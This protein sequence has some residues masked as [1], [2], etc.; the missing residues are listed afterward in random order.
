[1]NRAS[2]AIFAI[3]LLASSICAAA[4]VSY[5]FLRLSYVD[6]ELD[7]GP[8]DVDGDG[9][10]L[11]G[12]VSVF[13]NAFAFGRF[14]ALDMDFG[15]DA[16][17]L[18]IGGG[19]HHRITPK[20]DLVG[21]LGYVSVDLDSAGGDFDDDG[22]LVSGGV[23]SRLT[24]D[25]E[26]RAALNHRSMDEGDNDTEIE[27]GGDYYLTENWT[28]GGELAF[29]DDATTWSLSGRYAFK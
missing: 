28:V 3:S 18:E 23:R 11:G 5:D 27:L 10:E 25:I 13:N 17:R 6:T 22:I 9:F 1:M 24:A 19:Y 21:Q 29:G 8:L 20:I 15:V 16:S 2:A 4:D 14:A 7:V 12:S 26:G